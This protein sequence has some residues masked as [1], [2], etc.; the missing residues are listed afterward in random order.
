[1]SLWSGQLQERPLTGC[2]IAQLSLTGRRL[3]CRE[4]S[5]FPPDKRR[6]ADGPLSL[7]PIRPP[8][9]YHT[10]HHPWRCSSFNKWQGV[11]ISWRTAT[12]LQQRTIPASARPARTPISSETA[13][14][15]QL[16]TRYGPPD[17]FQDWRILPV[18][19]SG[20]TRRAVR[21]PCLPE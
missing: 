16:L 6:L 11:A 13:K 2:S 3:P 9:L 1:M 17:R 5:S 18:M 8:A 4:L 20:V 14:R 10:V 21:R 19:P 7:G 15:A 12:Q